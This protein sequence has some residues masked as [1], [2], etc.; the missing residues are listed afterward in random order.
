LALLRN[1]RRDEYTDART[2]NFF[3]RLF[4][5]WFGW[6]EDPRVK[7]VA[8][9]LNSL[10]NEEIIDL[11][12]LEITL[13]SAAESTA[14]IDRFTQF[15]NNFKAAAKS[16]Y[17]KDKLIEDK[18]ASLSVFPKKIA[19]AAPSL[20][21]T[22]GDL[23][24]NAIKLIYFLIR[25]GTF[26][27]IDAKD[28]ATLLKI[29]EA[30]PLQYQHIS[31][32]KEIINKLT[33]PPETKRAGL[34]RLIGDV[35]ADRGTNDYFTLMILAKLKELGAPIEVIASNH[36]VEFLHGFTLPE[37]DSEL[38]TQ[39]NS[40]GESQAASMEA[41]TSLL[42]VDH[43]TIRGELRGDMR[44][45]IKNYKSS[46]KLFN[47]ALSPDRKHITLYTHAP[48]GLETIR[49]LADEFG[50]D[51]KMNTA[52]NLAT[53]IDTINQKVIE[54]GGI[55][56]L[57]KEL[58]GKVEEIK[59][60]TKSVKKE[61]NDKATM[62]LELREKTKTPP[63]GNEDEL[64]AHN[65]LVTQHNGLL[66]EYEKLHTEYKQLQENLKSAADSLENSPLYLIIWNRYND[67]RQLER[68]DFGGRGEDQYSIS[69][70]HGHDHKSGMIL[71]EHIINLDSEF[72]KFVTIKPTHPDGKL[73]LSHK[74]EGYS[75][76]THSP[77]YH[78]HSEVGYSPPGISSSPTP[79]PVVSPSTI[80]TLSPTELTTSVSPSPT[81]HP[82]IDLAADSAT[83][84]NKNSGVVE[85]K[86]D[87]DED[88]RGLHK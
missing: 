5:S 75:S 81:T 1:F 69:Y 61:L 54:K 8:N 51:F 46:L 34:V 57:Y 77:E 36:D 38:A 83:P 50:T 76:P 71:D 35:L 39:N 42:N 17:L 7:A 65:A 9:Y 24:G 53:S 43:E 3:V 41:L 73:Y 21:I 13:P 2:G 10:D 45:A 11:S 29:Y 56:A 70:V 86:E 30:N 32:F 74:T 64:R 4:R 40:L 18:N 16:N 19:S 87:D 82:S 48:V 22:L 59:S 72:G 52:Y 67:N 88:T 15:I 79:S 33:L 14:L 58:F 47:Y 68:P 78:S 26:T 44:P 28:Y 31:K 6:F 85:S 80:T 49:K 55:E 25:E 84:R 63:V 12:R 23:H 37:N 66:S 27:G 20:Q 62:L 60:K